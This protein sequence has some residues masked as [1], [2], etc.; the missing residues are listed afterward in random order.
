[1][2][3]SSSTDV[4]NVTIDQLDATTL[5]VATGSAAGAVGTAESIAVQADAVTMMGTLDTA[6]ET[7]ST[8]RANI[9]ALE[10]QFSFHQA[11]IATSIENLSAAVSAIKDTDVAAEAAKLASAKVKTQA[12]VAAAAQA[13]QM[14]QDLL[15]LLQ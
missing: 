8:A 12:A 5:G 4:I 13:S 6:I 2:V 15:K 9:G 11:S 10:S 3:G 14:P 7:V 1:M